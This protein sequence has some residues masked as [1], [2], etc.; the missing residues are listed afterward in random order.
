MRK[1]NVK[2]TVSELKTF[3]T[4]KRMLTLILKGNKANICMIPLYYRNDSKF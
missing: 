3:L 4:T 2:S 1:F